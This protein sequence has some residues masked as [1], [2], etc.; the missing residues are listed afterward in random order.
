MQALGFRHFFL[1][2]GSLAFALPLVFV[3]GF[4]PRVMGCDLAPSD[5]EKFG[6]DSE[7]PRS[8]VAGDLPPA[9][10]KGMGK[11]S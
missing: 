9:K 3:V 10:G 5:T 8:F 6:V 11:G 1:C 2:T 7:N 4:H